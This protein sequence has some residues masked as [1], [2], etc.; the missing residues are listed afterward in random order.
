MIIINLSNAIAF[1]FLT[2]VENAI[3]SLSAKSRSFDSLGNP[4]EKKPEK[5]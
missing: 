1:C 3:E 2:K 4:I 5:V